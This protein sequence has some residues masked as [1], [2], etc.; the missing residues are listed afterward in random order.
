M[1]EEGAI[2]KKSDGK[3]YLTKIVSFK[4]PSGAADFVLG[5]SH[6]GWL[7]WKDKKGKTLNELFRQA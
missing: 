3:Y 4:S 6:N 2:V 5:G 1:E 7:E